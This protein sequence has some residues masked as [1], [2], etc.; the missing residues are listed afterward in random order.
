MDL[1]PPLILDVCR[2][3]VRG[4][5]KWQTQF[6]GQDCFKEESCMKSTIDVFSFIEKHKNVFK[7]VFKDLVVS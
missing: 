4:T 3:F 2:R 5:S 1:A 7:N 6:F